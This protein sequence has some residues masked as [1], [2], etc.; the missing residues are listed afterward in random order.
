[1]G[2]FRQNNDEYEYAHYGSYRAYHNA[3][4]GDAESEPES[5]SKVGFQCRLVLC[6]VI[7]SGYLFLSLSQRQEITK[8]L[9]QDYSENVFDFISEL[10]YTLDYEKTSIK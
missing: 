4:R 5:K 1:M 2:L 9:K 8:Y 6:I 3:N 7:F 10:S